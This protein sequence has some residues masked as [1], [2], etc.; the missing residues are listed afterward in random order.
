MQQ[1]LGCWHGSG[2][3]E[4]GLVAWMRPE[5]GPDYSRQQELGLWR[6]SSVNVVLAAAAG[7]RSVAWI[8]PECGLGSSGSRVYGM[9]LAG[10]WS[11]Q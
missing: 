8:W 11:G 6:R 4:R 7:A 1:E 10:M 5:C 9:D 3:K 2:W